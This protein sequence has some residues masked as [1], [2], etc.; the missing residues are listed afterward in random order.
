M[1]D[2]DDYDEIK[3]DFYK[4]LTCTTTYFD[5]IKLY[6]YIYAYA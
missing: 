3:T 1:A 4:Q 2:Y 6:N 5:K